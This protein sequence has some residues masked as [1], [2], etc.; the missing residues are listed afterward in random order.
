MEVLVSSS[1]VWEEGTGGQGG[2]VSR[3]LAGRDPSRQ[4]SQTQS[5]VQLERSRLQRVG[6]GGGGGGGGEGGEGGFV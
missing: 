5:V 2:A 3:R 6:G 4:Q 1:P